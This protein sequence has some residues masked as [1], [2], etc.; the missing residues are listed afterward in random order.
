MATMR[1]LR[2][3]SRGGPQVL[4]YEEAPR[5]CAVSGEVLVE[6]H[7][8]AITFD[9]L[10]WDETWTRDGI[11]RTPTIP[12]H[13]FSG[14]VAEL[15]HGT[16]G[17]TP[18]EEVYG[19]VPFDRDGAAA[20]FVSTPASQVA[21]KPVN[22]SHVEAAALPL[23]ALT[24]SQAL[25]DH[26][27]LVAG[28]RVLV[29]GGAGG[30]GGYAM[31][32]AASLGAEVT[33]TSVGK[34]EY[35][36]SLGAHRVVDVSSEDFDAGDPEF[37]IVIDTVGGQLLDR[38]Y[39]FLRKGG[40]LVTLQSPPDRARAERCGV[41]AMFF[42]VTADSDELSRIARLA[43]SGSLRATIAQTFPLADGA[44]ATASRGKGNRAP[45]KTV[46]LVAD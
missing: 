29:H 8:A 23:P 40:R 45:G 41:D 9:E 16:V 13:E 27:S 37:D 36:K 31:Q 28:E 15:G 24:A 43:D 42:V 10:T 22:L 33:A 5:P 34:V 44:A 17:V 38:S 11:E 25:V 6:V 32:L 19:M 2:A 3:H 26:A 1:A 12:S 35:V 4:V 7:G 18:G 39:S 30:V 20:E 14:V 21:R 46:L